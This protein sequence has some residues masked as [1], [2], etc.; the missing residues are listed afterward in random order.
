MKTQQ[1][2]LRTIRKNNVLGIY[3][4]VMVSLSIA[5]IVSSWIQ[6]ISF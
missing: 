3:T 6:H 2:T 1:S 4:L 5:Y